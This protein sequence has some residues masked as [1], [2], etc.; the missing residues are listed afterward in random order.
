MASA[1]RQYYLELPEPL[2]TYAQYSALLTLID[3][4]A[5]YGARTKALR[6]ILSSVARV[7]GGTYG[8]LLRILLTL[9]RRVAARAAPGNSA[10]DLAAAFVRRCPRCL[11]V[12]ACVV[13]FTF[14]VDVVQAAVIARPAK[15]AKPSGSNVPRKDEP[16]WVHSLAAF[17]LA[18]QV[19]LCLLNDIAIEFYNRLR[20]GWSKSRHGRV[21]R[22]D[23]RGGRKS[24]GAAANGGRRREDAE[25]RTYVCGRC[26]LK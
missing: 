18:A 17:D 22:F 15:P 14:V 24:A 7:A 4:A 25:H 1:L 23:D 16:A 8:A 12:C 19:A 2:L 3:E 13:S 21:G 9:L 26:E 5:G 6:P 11:C 10:A 20:L